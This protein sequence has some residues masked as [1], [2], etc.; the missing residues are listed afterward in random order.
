MK[1]IEL[2]VVANS[3]E[4][5]SRIMKDLAKYNCNYSL[6]K[7]E[8]SM[9]YTQLYDKLPFSRLGD[10]T[11][12]SNSEY[13]KDMKYY[14]GVGKILSSYGLLPTQKGYKYSI[15]CIRLI[16]LYGLDN[17]SM[18]DD[19]YPVISNWYKVSQTSVEHNIRNAIY[20][21]WSKWEENIDLSSNMKHFKSRP[22]NVKFLKHI[23]KISSNIVAQCY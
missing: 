19:V 13:K 4:V 15:E 12:R 3:E 14:E 22:S 11:I 5:A 7:E 6:V 18:K 21:A 8:M 10:V 20:W 16:N 17:F 2:K 23:A 1:E 9:K